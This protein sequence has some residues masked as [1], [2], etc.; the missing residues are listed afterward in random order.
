VIKADARLSIQ[1]IELS[2][3]LIN[4]FQPRY[5]TRLNHYVDLMNKYPDEYA[6]F[7]SVVPSNKYEG[8]FVVLD[9]HHRYLASIVTGRKD[10]LAVVIEEAG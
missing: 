6:G 7:L 8:L 10:V 2:K 9:G 4:E 3:L 1:K 5:M